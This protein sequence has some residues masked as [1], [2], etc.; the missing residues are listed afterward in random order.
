ML[1]APYDPDNVFARILSGEIPAAVIAESERTL[2]FM[3]AF[4]QTRG[5]CLV[6]PKAPV[7]NILDVSRKDLSAVTDQTQKIARAVDAALGPDG[8]V[9]TQFNG[10]PAGQTVF[11]LHMHVI[12]R[13]SGGQDHP[14]GGAPAS[15]MDEL[16]TL[17]ALI[18]EHL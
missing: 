6:I 17:A 7:R 2:A 14:H 10:Q 3:D 8:I 12:P 13:Y 1:H 4:P 15:D 16:K 18:K 11:H 5:H 9:V